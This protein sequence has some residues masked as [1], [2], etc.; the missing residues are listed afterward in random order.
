MN[1]YYTKCSF[2]VNGRSVDRFLQED[3]K[4]IHTVIKSAKV[5]GKAVDIDALNKILA[6]QLSG[7]LEQSAVKYTGH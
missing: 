4:K 6:K 7:V 2:L 5:D 1:M 3:L